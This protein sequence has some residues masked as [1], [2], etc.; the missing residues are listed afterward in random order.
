MQMHA[1]LG[2]HR[3]V[4]IQPSV[5]GTNDACLL[6]ALKQWGERARGVAVLDET[7]GRAQLGDMHGAGIRGVRVNLEVSRHSDATAALQQLQM[8]LDTLDGVR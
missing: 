7:F 8:T 5:Y 1:S 4:L 2:V 3:V 6:D